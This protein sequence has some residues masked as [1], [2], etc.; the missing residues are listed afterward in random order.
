MLPLQIMGQQKQENEQYEDAQHDFR[1]DLYKNNVVEI[2]IEGRDAGYGLITYQYSDDDE[3]IHYIILS[4]C[5]GI[6]SNLR[7]LK[8]DLV[9]MHEQIEDVRDIFNNAYIKINNN[10]CDQGNECVYKGQ[11]GDIMIWDIVPY[12]DLIKIIPEFTA[13]YNEIK[14]GD[15]L[16]FLKEKTTYI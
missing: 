11:C 8:V 1:K 13:N 12:V 4:H 10:W 5:H 16:Y 14:K 15:V 6:E 3:E 2:K 9:F 7:Q